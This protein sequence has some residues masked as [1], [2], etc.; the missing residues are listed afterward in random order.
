MDDEGA[1]PGSRDVRVVLQ[2]D[3]I[4]RIVG[5]RLGN[6][7]V[8]GCVLALLVI[9]MIVFGPASDSRFIYTDF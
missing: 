1:V 2:S 7:L 6:P 5:P 4:A 8:L 9:A 3:P